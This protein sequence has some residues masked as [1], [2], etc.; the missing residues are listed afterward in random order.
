[1]REKCLRLWEAWQQGL[2]QQPTP[3]CKGEREKPSL[4]LSMK[5]ST[6]EPERRSEALYSLKAG[7]IIRAERGFKTCGIRYMSSVEPFAGSISLG[8]RP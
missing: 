6:E 5:E 4:S 3:C 2:L 1:M 8:E 7:S